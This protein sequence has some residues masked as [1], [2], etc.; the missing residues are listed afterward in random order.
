MSTSARE[1]LRGG[2]FS[3]VRR[4]LVAAAGGYLRNVLREP[5]VTCRVCAAPVDGFDRCWRCAQAQCFAGVAD[6]VAPL[7]YAIAG[8]PSAALVCDYKNHPARRVREHH[9]AVLDALVWL[10]I[11]RHERCIAAVAGS[12]VALRVVVPSLTSR[13]GTHP[14]AQIARAAGALGPATLLPAPTAVCERV[15]RADKFVL[16]PD[17]RVDGRHVLVLDDIWTTGSNAQS[18]ALALRRAGAAAVSVLVVGRWLRPN[19]PG[20]ARFID[21]RLQ[22]GYDPDLCPVTGG[23][24]P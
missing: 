22:R 6:V 12:P 9:S 19:H 3:Q 11:T 4:A 16:T 8:T 2:D 21:T 18:A 5:R 13:P 20:T 15:V 1:S 7:A 17:A 14:F 10:G 24:C 23:A